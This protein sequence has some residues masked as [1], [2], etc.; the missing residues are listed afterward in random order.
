MKHCL[1]A[2]AVLALAL[3]LSAAETNGSPLMKIGTADA[4]KFYGREMIVTGQVAQVSIRPGIVFLNM[5]KPYP[6]SPFTLIIFPAA[7]NQFG[8][9]RSLR[10]ATIEA[11]GTITNYHNRAEIVLEKAKQLKVTGQPPTNAPVAR[12][13][14]R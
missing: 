14:S 10:G 13:D 4:K 5:D 12:P 9:L 2:L 3:H 11:T 8:N 6:E 1:P 7:T